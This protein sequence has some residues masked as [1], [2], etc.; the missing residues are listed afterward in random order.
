MMRTGPSIHQAEMGAKG[1]GVR[2]W[3]R[4]D[5]P[6]PALLGILLI[7]L[8]A[9]GLVWANTRW[10][11]GLRGDSYMYVSGARNLAAGLGYSRVSGGGE[12]KPITHFPPLYSMV[13]AGL[14]LPGWDAV[15]AARGLA[16]VLMGVNTALVAVLSWRSAQRPW[17]GVVG[18]LLFGLNPLFL[19]VGSWAMA[20]PLFLALISATFLALVAAEGGPARRA[21]LPGLLAGLA[22]L[23]RYAGVAAIVAGLGFFLWP[24]PERRPAWRHAASY[25]TAAVLPVA[26]WMARNIAVSGTTTNRMIAWHPITASKAAEAGATFSEWILPDI[27]VAREGWLAWM[28]IAVGLAFLAVAGMAVLRSEPP[29]AERA[30]SVPVRAG[31][32]FVLA[33]AAVLLGNLLVLDSSTPLDARI[34]SPLLMALVPMIVCGLVQAWGHPGRVPKITLALA[35][36]VLLTGFA[37]D[38]RRLLDQGWLRGW[39]FSHRLWKSSALL[40]AIRELPPTTLYTNEP[41]LV[42][43]H[44]GRAGYIIFGGTDPV[45]GAPRAGYDEWLSNARR[46]LSDGRAVL[47]LVNP[48][49]LIADPG[50]RA[51]VE[52]LSAGL[53]TIGTYEDGVILSARAAP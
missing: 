13:L 25:F 27:M 1:A 38:D 23:T 11:V 14:A 53:V 45:T 28:G 52:A 8:L 47:V 33:Y 46:D 7:A 44:T 51:M 31:S 17:A 36:L 20:E 43:F 29:H 41:D 4:A 35:A 21:V 34:L 15:D 2:R 22:C 12:V 37:E 18:A 30:T 26:A 19:D 50:D 3:P 48:D 42:Y 10:G 40:Q 24:Q 49:A 9:C 16:V 5:R 6:R 32:W 39:G